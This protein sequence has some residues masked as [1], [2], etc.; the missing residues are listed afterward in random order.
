M[1]RNSEISIIRKEENNFSEIFHEN[2]DFEN[3][4][5][6]SASQRDKNKNGLERLSSLES[7]NGSIHANSYRN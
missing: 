5:F 4:L 1:T 7:S 3:Y 2:R 6:E